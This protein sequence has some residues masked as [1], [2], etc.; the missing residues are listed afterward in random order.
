MVG[1]FDT[2]IEEKKW[3]RIDHYQDL[4]V[5]VQKIWNCRRVSVI[6]IVIG[7]LGTASKHVPEDV[8]LK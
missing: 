6:P 3:E 5:E 4:K 2:C 8:G 1:P 7:A